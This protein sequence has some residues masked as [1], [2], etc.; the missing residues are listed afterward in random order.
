MIETFNALV[1]KL[2]DKLAPVKT[3]QSAPQVNEE[4]HD[5]M[6]KRMQLFTPTDITKAMAIFL[7]R[8]KN[9]MT[10]TIYITKL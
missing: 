1:L 5:L 10:Q 4:I 8:F 6:A 2:Y 9:T 3:Q 7:K